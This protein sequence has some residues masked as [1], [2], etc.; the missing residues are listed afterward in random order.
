MEAVAPGP[1]TARQEP[2]GFSLRHTIC[3]CQKFLCRPWGLFIALTLCVCVLCPCASVYMYLVTEDDKWP[4]SLDGHHVF[5]SLCCI[6]RYGFPHW[7]MHSNKSEQAHE[8]ICCHLLQSWG[9][10]CLITVIFTSSVSTLADLKVPLLQ[11]EWNLLGTQL[12]LKWPSNKLIKKIIGFH[13]DSH[14]RSF[15]VLL[16]QF[17]LYSV[18]DVTTH[19]QSFQK[20]KIAWSFLRLDWKIPHT[21]VRM[22]FTAAFEVSN[23]EFKPTHSLFNACMSVCAGHSDWEGQRGVGNHGFWM[24][25]FFFNLSS[26]WASFQSQTTHT[27]QSHAERAARKSWV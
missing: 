20:Q 25:F 5:M 13:E 9:L 18:N 17:S 11:E 23:E 26:L 8:Y 4:D 19:T 1:A 24:F 21:G 2:K 6:H 12:K 10:L 3:V 22:A 7:C 15:A 27:F 16:R 14:N